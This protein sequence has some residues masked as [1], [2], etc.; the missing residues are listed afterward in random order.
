MIDLG[1]SMRACW[2][3]AIVLLL[4]MLAGGC[5]KDRQCCPPPYPQAPIA[6]DCQPVERQPLVAD[7]S[8]LHNRPQPFPAR[9]Y[10]KLTERD[11]QCLAAMYAPNAR[12]LDQEAEAVLAQR[13]GHHQADGN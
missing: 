5:A 9:S 7:L 2:H 6:I 1:L 10:C 4:E 8:L 11:A 3:I 13:A 12:L